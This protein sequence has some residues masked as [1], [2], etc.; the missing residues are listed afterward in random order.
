MNIKLTPLILFL[1]FLF[2]LVISIVFSKYFP[3]REGF[4]SFAENKSPLEP[5]FLPTY[6][7]S[8]TSVVKLYDNAFFDM[9]N[10]NLIEVDGTAIVSSSSDGNVSGGNIVGGNV[11]PTSSSVH[12]TISK[13][14][15]LKREEP[16]LPVEYGAVLTETGE[17]V[18]VD[19][20]ESKISTTS[21][22]YLAKMYDTRSEETDSY[23]IAYITWGTR[24]YMHII[25]V[26]SSPK[27]VAAYLMGEN[28]AG[29]MKIYP[30][31]TISIGSYVDD[32]DANN[33]KYVPVPL[34]DASAN[35]YQLSKSV[36]YDQRNGHLVIFNKATNSIKVYGRNGGETTSY[37]T[38]KPTTVAVSN[39]DPWL[40]NDAD[41]NM[42]VYFQ[43]DKK[44]LIAIIQMD[45]TDSSKFILGKV[46]RFNNQGEL[47]QAPTEG[48]VVSPTPAPKMPTDSGPMSE[49]YKWLAYWSTHVL[50]EDKSDDDYIRKTQIVPPVCPSCPSCP[51]CPKNG[52]VGGICTNCGGN[53]GSGT[54]QMDGSSTVKD[55]SPAT[56]TAAPTV[57][58]PPST[59]SSATLAQRAG[60]ALEQTV[61]STGNV[62]TKAITTTG[63]VLKTTGGEV[64]SL[65]RSAGSGTVD[66]L[67]STASGTKDILK[68]TGAGTADLLK[69]TASGATD[70]LKSAGSGAVGL[71]KSTGTGAASMMS[72]THPVYA[73][74]TIYPQGAVKRTGETQRVAPAAMYK[75]QALGPS[76]YYSMYGAT[77][78]KGDQFIPI[79]AD[80]SAFR[81]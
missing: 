5:V 77:Q 4:I 11:S 53:G 57:S 35:I 70:L 56:A 12:T 50:Y 24:T 44:T 73:Q 66:I 17:V 23:Q 33:G 32:S 16:S 71:L 41:N 54:L 27:H 64:S 22:I 81:K 76:D 28:S 68:S 69:S 45:P 72:P 67:K 15:V 13:I 31:S 43:H 79:T 40:V 59:E 75:G 34:Y 39:F 61:E 14:Y 30:E 38:S 80:F 6:S 52:S 10:A 46:A 19:T 74:R 63:D 60:N 62:A 37:T 7:S 65:V 47:E 51:S 26:G 18:P 20:P 48:P 25:R 42:V 49:Y 2:V 29:H 58:V 78:P 3:A 36:R 8:T 9:R 21:N 1:F 55:V